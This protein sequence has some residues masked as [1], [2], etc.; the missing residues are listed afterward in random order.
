MNNRGKLNQTIQ[1]VPTSTMSAIT[2]YTPN[3][4]RGRAFKFHNKS[5][6]NPRVVGGDRSGTSTSK[7]ANSKQV[8][9]NINDLIKLRS[10]TNNTNYGV[11]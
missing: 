3:A 5:L 6:M 11:Q 8:A 7:N 10:P 9:S 2:G 1:D 4:E